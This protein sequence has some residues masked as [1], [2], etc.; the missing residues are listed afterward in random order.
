MGKISRR[1]DQDYFD[2]QSKSAFSIR[3]AES[4][5]VDQAE[6]NSDKNLVDAD[7]D[8]VPS[9]LRELFGK[10]I[11]GAAEDTSLDASKAKHSIDTL[12]ERPELIDTGPILVSA[13][14]RAAD[15]GRERSTA[16]FRG[17]MRIDY[18]LP[19]RDLRVVDGGVYW[20]AAAEDAAGAALAEAA[21]DHRLVWLDLEIE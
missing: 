1:I 3:N 2:T 14:A 15:A 8:D 18:L 5:N 4:V 9:W 13:G 19:S 6:L 12:L 21:S 20:P 10:V 7:S 17:G 11:D 16:V